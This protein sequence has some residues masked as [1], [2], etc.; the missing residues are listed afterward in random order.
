MKDNIFAALIILQIIEAA[1]IVALFLFDS[2]TLKI[3]LWLSLSLTVFWGAI[4]IL[5][6][7]LAGFFYL[8]LGDEEGWGILAIVFLLSLFIFLG[9]SAIPGFILN[10]IS[11]KLSK[12]YL[13]KVSKD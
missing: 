2:L 4:S 8:E 3:S 10:L 9:I 5:S 12:K 11:F 6:V 7:F 1:V 13:K